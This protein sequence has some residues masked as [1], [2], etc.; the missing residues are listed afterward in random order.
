MPTVAVIGG[1][2]IGP[3]V[4]HVTVDVLQALGL[5]L[6]FDHLTEVSAQRFLASG[7]TLTE[8][9][10]GRLRDADAIF[11]GAIGDPRVTSPDYARGVVLRLRA[12]LGLYANV[13]PARL[14][15]DRLSPL[16]NPDSREIDL[17]VVRENNEGLYAGVGGV[18]RAGTPD[19][20]AVDEEINTYL[21]V[22]RIIEYAFSVARRS[23]CMVDKSNAVKFGGQ[24]WQRCWAK[25]CER[26]RDVDCSH[27]YVDA[28]AMKLVENPSA[29]DVL[30][31]NNSYGDILSDLTA[32]LAGGIGFTPSANVNPQTRRAMF[33]PVH[34]SA[35]DL[36]GKAQANPVGAI[37]SGAML[38]DFLGHQQEARAVRDAVQRTVTLGR[39]TPDAGGDL[40]T[41]EVGRAVLSE[42]WQKQ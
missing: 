38:L 12:E 2:G 13:R 28:A 15:A 23:V 14:F 41:V 20:V 34:G 17:I 36:A 16:G 3:E 25:A 42:L 33:E 31:T 24:L 40:S 5:G 29:F 8:D 30:V 4:T 10:V 27:L 9:E 26:H 11:L 22:S 1:D 39:C 6:D 19:E 21:G 35:P 7:T 37:L 18:L 32:V